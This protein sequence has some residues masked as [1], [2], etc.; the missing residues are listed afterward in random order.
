MKISC[1]LKE[2]RYS[3]VKARQIYRKQCCHQHS[4]PSTTVLAEVI[5][6]FNMTRAGAAQRPNRRDTVALAPVMRRV[7]RRL[8]LHEPGS[9]R[10]PTA[11]QPLVFV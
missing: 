3:N 9:H 2:A 4:S 7:N 11:L 8:L 10:V 6:F 1:D 5:F